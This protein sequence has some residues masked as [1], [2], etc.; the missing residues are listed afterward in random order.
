LAPAA[1]RAEQFRAVTLADY[2]EAT[3]KLPQVANAVAA[4][5][6]TGS[7]HTV[8]VGVDPR[9][10]GDLVTESGGRTRLSENLEA[11]VRAY[12]DRYRLAGYDLEIRSGEYVPLEIDLSLCVSPGYFRGDVERAVK[13]AL[14]NHLDL[15]QSGGLFDPDHFTFGQPVYL[16]QVYAAVEAVEGVDSVVVTRFQRFGEPENQALENGV[17]PMGAWEIARLDNDPNFME[18][19]VLR[20]TTRGGV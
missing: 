5:R 12:L 6:Y 4:F 8:F 1:F 16:S 20:I 7:W 10:A 19:G 9:F 15:D 18:R 2:V 11:S 14:V 3:K 13:S 17:I